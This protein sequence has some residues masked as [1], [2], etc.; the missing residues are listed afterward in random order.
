MPVYIGQ[1]EPGFEDPVGLMIAC[2]RRIERFL[3]VLVDLA[4]RVHGNALTDGESGAIETALRYFR[5]AAPHHTADEESGLFPNLEQAYGGS[6]S[7]LSDLERDHR[8][9]ERLHSTVDRLGLIWL[10]HGTLDDS[11]VKKVQSALAELS[12]LYREH[13]RIEEEHVFPFARRALSRQV[14]ERIGRDMA[15]RRGVAYI[16][17]TVRTIATAQ[18]EAQ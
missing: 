5:D 1:P 18:M 17:P 9:A 14:L 2:H 11:N 13:I 12:A 15:S 4:M 8:R 16:P 6:V 3:A 7:Y 10:K